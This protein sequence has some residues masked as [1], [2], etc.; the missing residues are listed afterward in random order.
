[1][2]TIPGSSEDAQQARV[3]PTYPPPGSPRGMLSAS[4]GPHQPT[5]SSMM[6]QTGV[7]GRE[8]FRAGISSKGAVALSR[9]LYEG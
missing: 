5:D 7:P 2:L 3:R 6:F 8:S 9:Y 4:L 1:M